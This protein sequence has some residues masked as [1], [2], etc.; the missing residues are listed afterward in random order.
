MNLLFFSI[1]L[2]DRLNG[3]FKLNVK[4]EI[5]NLTYKLNFPGTKTILEVKSNIYTLNDIPVRN[6]LWKGWPPNI[7][8]DSVTLAGSGIS[9]PEHNLSVD[10]VPTKEVKRVGFVLKYSLFFSY[11]NFNSILGY[12]GLG[13][14][15]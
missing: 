12:S 8:D 2:S 1:Q 15:R 9:L 4:D 13:G 10:R 11:F 6:Q 3:T 5:N 7:K 14:H